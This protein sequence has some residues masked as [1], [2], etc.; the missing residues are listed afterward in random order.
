MPRLDRTA[1]ICEALGLEFYVGPP[2]PAP[3][4]APGPGTDVPAASLVRPT[5]ELV[6][7]VHEAGHDPIPD[8]LWPDLLERYQSKEPK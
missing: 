1:Q 5:Q 6:R 3:E 4:A 7:L 8:D 2:R